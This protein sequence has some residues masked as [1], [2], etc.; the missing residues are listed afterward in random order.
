MLSCF[1]DLVIKKIMV[2]SEFNLDARF[3]IYRLF[4]RNFSC[5]WVM[6]PICL[7]LHA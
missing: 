7:D 6:S 5:T 2:Q 4:S 3:K 1:E